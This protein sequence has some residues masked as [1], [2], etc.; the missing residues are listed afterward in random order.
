L[1][2]VARFAIRSNFTL[3][4]C[5]RKFADAQQGRGIFFVV[6]GLTACEGL[7]TFSNRRWNQKRLA[8]RKVAF[9]L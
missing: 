9:A 2:T 3:G 6:K 8:L 1:T 5:G 4:K 7:D